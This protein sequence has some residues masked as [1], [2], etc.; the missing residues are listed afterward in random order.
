M[1]LL[2]HQR[3]F[4]EFKFKFITLLHHDLFLL[5][6]RMSPCLVPHKT[7]LGTPNILQTYLHPRPPTLQLQLSHN[8]DFLTTSFSFIYNIISPI[9]IRT[10]ISSYYFFIDEPFFNFL[11]I[12]I[13]TSRCCLDY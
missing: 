10:R 5:C 6:W 1:C 2:V 8:R 13:I 9:N 3:N 4:K 7:W 12:L 11:H